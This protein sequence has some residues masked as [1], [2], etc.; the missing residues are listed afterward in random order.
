MNRSSAYRRHAQDCVEV[1][2]LVTSEKTKSCLLGW[3]QSF[4]RLAQ[5]AEEIERAEQVGHPEPDEEG[6][7]DPNVSAA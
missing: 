3:A 7:P 4:Q 5:R 1:A 2:E 6:P